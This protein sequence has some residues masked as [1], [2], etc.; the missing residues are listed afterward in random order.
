MNPTENKIKFHARK[1][2]VVMIPCDE[3][4]P[5]FVTVSSRDEVAWVCARH[6]QEHLP[7]VGIEVQEYEVAVYGA[8]NFDGEQYEV[9]MYSAEDFDNELPF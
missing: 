7:F 8:E 9:E 1:T 4:G 6:L 2:A 5:H 3:H